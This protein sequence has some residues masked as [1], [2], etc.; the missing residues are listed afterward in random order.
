MEVL[1]DEK[2]AT[3]ASFLR[4]ALLHF[5]ELGVT[6]RK[7]PKCNGLSYRSKEFNAMRESFGLK[8]SRT[9]PYRPAP[10]GK[11]ERLIQTALRE[12]AYGPTWQS[13]DE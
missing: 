5:Q 9:R 13:S 4:R 6:V 8:H 1:A 10:N 7:Q 11:A 12:W 2:K 3:T